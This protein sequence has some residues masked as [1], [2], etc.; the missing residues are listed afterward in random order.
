L[1]EARSVRR[2]WFHHATGWPGQPLFV[3]VPQRLVA[4]RASP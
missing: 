4:L 2:W 1:R 3:L